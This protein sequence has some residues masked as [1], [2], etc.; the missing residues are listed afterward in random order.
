MQEKIK[1]TPQSQH[2]LYMKSIL[3]ENQF[4]RLALERYF[5]D[6]FKRLKIANKIE[7]LGTYDNFDS[8]K[9]EKLLIELLEE[10]LKADR[11]QKEE[12]T[13][14]KA[15]Y[16]NKP[17]KYDDVLYKVKKYK[18]MEDQIQEMKL[19]LKGYRKAKSKNLPALLEVDDSIESLKQDSDNQS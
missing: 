17:Q 12:A 15:K 7:C 8:S 14:K 11:S 9:A 4:F 18:K 13:R 1:N 5:Q 6:N 16:N 19:F 3:I 10:H 2:F